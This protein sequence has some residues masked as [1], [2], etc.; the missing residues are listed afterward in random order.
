MKYLINRIMVPRSPAHCKT[1][2]EVLLKFVLDEGATHYLPTALKPPPAAEKPNRRFFRLRAP[3]ERIERRVEIS[4]EPPRRS[5]GA[6]VPGLRGGGRA[7]FRAA[8]IAGQGRDDTPQCARLVS[9][10]RL[11]HARAE[12]AV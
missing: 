11:R 7:N 3:F 6:S 10:G 4:A 5:S 2:P 12:D 8:V 9:Q 1:P